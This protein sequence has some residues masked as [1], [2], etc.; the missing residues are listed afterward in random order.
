[1]TADRPLITHW[2]A[3]RFGYVDGSTALV[4]LPP[5]DCPPPACFGVPLWRGAWANFWIRP[6]NRRN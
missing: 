6:D 3:G 5:S 4:Y 2:F 1:M